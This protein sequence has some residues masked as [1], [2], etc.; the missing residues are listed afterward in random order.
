MKRKQFT[1]YYSFFDVISCMEDP[2]E[3][4]QTYD[5][6]CRY[7]LLGQKPDFE[8]LSREAKMAVKAFMPVLDAA[9]KKAV[10]GANGGRISKGCSKDTARIEQ[11]CSKDTARIGQGYSKDIASKKKDKEEDKGKEENI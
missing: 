4:A 3:R 5:V 11:G 9:R 7:A 1:F 2:V 6:L 8:S 10:G